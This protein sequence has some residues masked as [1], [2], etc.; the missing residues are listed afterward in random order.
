[1]EKNLLN[2]LDFDND[3]DIET[4]LLD[5]AKMADNIVIFGAGIGGKATMDLLNNN[6]LGQKVR[7]FSDNNLNKVG[8]HYCDRNVIHPN[9]IKEKT[10]PK[11]LIIISSTAY[12]IVSKQ[13]IGYGID[14][15][16]L[17]YFQL[18]RLSEKSEE[19]EY[20]RQHI[21]DFESIYNKLQDEKSKLIYRCILNYRITNNI[22][23]L[24]EMSSYIDSEENQYFDNIL[25]EQYYFET[26]FVDAGAYTGDTLSQ[27]HKNLPDFSGEYYAFEAGKDIYIKLLSNCDTENYGFKVTCFNIAVWNEEGSLRFDTSENDA[28][29]KVNEEGEVVFCN[30]LD[31]LLKNC[32]V[33]FIKM[34][35]EGSERKA[36][37][38]AVGIIRNNKPIMAICIYHKREDFYDIPQLIESIIPNEYAFYI[39]QY[40]F[41]QSETVLYALPNSRKKILK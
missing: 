22:L 18:A 28:G 33:D 10:S 1:M 3:I 24:K 5:K 26:G 17:Y 25:L 4:L 29:S 2:V 12:D 19:K 14:E 27:M 38:G 15:D 23:Y 41:G 8:K 21:S 39:R 9:E 35:I 40:R 11:R 16:E 20:I 34:D 6:L 31:N 7:Y 36:L 30:S 37:E 32:K 13:L